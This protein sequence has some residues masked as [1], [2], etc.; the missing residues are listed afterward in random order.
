MACQHIK[1]SGKRR[2][3]PRSRAACWRGSTSARTRPTHGP[4]SAG[5]VACRPA[6][7]A[8]CTQAHRAGLPSASGHGRCLLA[9]QHWL[10]DMPCGPAPAVQGEPLS[11]AALAD[12]AHGACGV[13]GP[14]AARH[15]IPAQQLDTLPWVPPSED[16]LRHRPRGRWLP[17]GH[18]ALRLPLFNMAAAPGARLLSL[19]WPSRARSCS[20]AQG[21]LTCHPSS[22]RCQL[23]LFGR[24]QELA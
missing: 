22:S 3:S 20:S 14:P 18:T 10:H 9:H 19:K 21:R 5:L 23:M 16:Y 15:A 17:E 12:A 6:L 13:Q 1:F 2:R 4:A 24:G 8:A 7:P 11:W